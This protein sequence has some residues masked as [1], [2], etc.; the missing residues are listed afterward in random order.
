MAGLEAFLLFVSFHRR[1]PC[2]DKNVAFA[3]RLF[4]SSNVEASNVARTSHVARRSS[5]Q[6]TRRT[7]K[8]RTSPAR[9][10]SRVA[11][12]NTS[13]F[14]AQITYPHGKYSKY[15]NRTGILEGNFCFLVLIPRSRETPDT[16]SS[17]AGAHSR[18]L[19]GSYAYSVLTGAWPLRSLFHAKNRTLCGIKRRLISETCFNDALTIFLAE[20]S[21]FL[22]VIRRMVCHITT[23]WFTDTIFIRNMVFCHSRIWVI[24]FI[25]G[26]KPSEHCI[27]N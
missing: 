27:C 10:M 23:I 24:I 2:S 9:R 20:I 5:H 18:V 26:V 13:R 16:Q 14:A 11:P 19:A 12:A 3:E 6:P 4:F 8:R 25:I 1:S 17:R 22:Y 21:R 15:N 7:S